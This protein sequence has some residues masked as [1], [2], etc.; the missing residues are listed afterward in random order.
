[1]S[2]KEIWIMLSV[3]LFWGSAIAMVFGW[4]VKIVKMENR[5]E[6]VRVPNESKHKRK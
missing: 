6:S 3:F 5:F 2:G 1:M 4:I